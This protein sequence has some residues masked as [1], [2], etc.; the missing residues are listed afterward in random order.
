M[1][2]P[3]STRAIA[4]PAISP[5]TRAANP[6]VLKTLLGQSTVFLFRKAYLEA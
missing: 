3:M 5:F 6:M 1:V 2:L 4:K